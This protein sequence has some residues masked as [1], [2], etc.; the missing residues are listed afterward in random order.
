MADGDLNAKAGLSVGDFK[1]GVNEI[2][3][4]MRVLSSEFKAS[5][6]ALGDWSKDATGLEQRIGFLNKSIDLQK[7]KV[8]ALKGQME[9]EARA[10]KE[11]AA[12]KAELTVKINKATEELHKMQRELGEDEKSLADVKQGSDEAGK[13]V[14]DLGENSQ[15]AASGMDTL[16]S[17][18]GGLFTALKVG[19]GTV[20]ALVGAVVALTGAIGGLVFSTANSSAELV[21]LSAKTGISTTRLQEMA[22]VGKQLG[23]SQETMVSSMAR[24]TRTMSSAQQQT[25]DFAAAQAEAKAKGKEFD[26]QLGDAAAAFERLGVR[27]IGV[28]GQLRDNEAVFADVITA[29]GRVS[30]ESERDALAMSIFGKSAQELN[31]L[32][33]AGAGEMA[34]LSQ[35]AHDV[36]AVMSEEDV[37]AFEAF[38]DT[39]ASLQAGLKG[40]LGTLAGAFLPGFQ[41]FFDQAGG[42]LKEFSAI[43]RGSDGDL[44][45]MGTG[46]I[47]LIQK[48]VTDLA[49]QGPQFLKG[50]L[51]IL[52]GLINAII[53]SLPGMLPVALDI[54][55]TLLDFL[56]TALP[57]L[58]DAGV[59]ILLMLIN[60]IVTGLPGLVEAALKMI[61]T[62]V[63][64]LADAM[65]KLIPM[66]ATI[67]PQII[68][69]L[70]KN[71]PLLID[72]ALQLILALANGLVAALPILIPAIPVIV[73][74]IFDALIASLPLIFEAAGQLIA[75]LIMGLITSIP[76][77][78]T[79]SG[80]LIKTV[81][82]VLFNSGPSL[83]DA[84]K[85][86][87]DGIWKG[88]QGQKDVF[89]SQLKKWFADM[90]ASV[91]SALGINS[92]ST[93]FADQVGAQ[94]PPGVGK[95]ILGAMPGLERQLAAAMGGLARNYNIGVNADLA[96]G[97]ATASG[98]RAGGQVYNIGDIY[99][100]ARG[101]KDP[102]AVGQATQAGV[103]SAMRAK[104][105]G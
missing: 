48:I 102:Q 31:P 97:G 80:Q 10:G 88:I 23:T 77:L 85:A 7:Q 65:P 52:Q 92:P 63:Q 6:A 18:S 47:K 27:T 69:I 15:E 14:K 45:K 70:M 26:G 90:V 20:L 12:S 33:K 68:T 58:M 61:I 96:F 40:T 30:N 105:N 89:F 41:A 57:Q 39:M 95:G 36:G 25:A 67:I 22:Y 35:K 50:G 101:A 72:A 56:V 5:A 9:A 103:L 91:K 28:N 71:L 73:R 59:Q 42:Y 81:L 66:I 83:Q 17:I 86:V 54:I 93:L 60:G 32:I 79:A 55:K 1:A 29:L 98:G 3:R 38:D 16:R 62:L 51:T 75:T 104:G 21:D 34:A 78:A 53:Q 76:L 37:A 74:A 13:S 4:S 100:D 94:I 84:G 99:V 46:V 2:N 49:A 82:D 87:V 44:G 64:G 11:T 19:L 43:V 8:D 24:L